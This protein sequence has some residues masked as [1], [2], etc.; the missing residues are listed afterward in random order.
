MTGI[1]AVTATSLL[2]MTDAVANW[3]INA[4]SEGLRAGSAE[5]QGKRLQ[6][7]LETAGRSG[8]PVFLEPG[9]YR[10]SDVTLP[11]QTVLHGVPG[12]TVLEYAGGGHFLF[13]ENNDQVSL[14]GLTLEGGLLPVDEY[15]DALVRINNAQRLDV[16]DCAFVDS[17]SCAIR[18]T[19]SSGSISKNRITTAVGSAAFLGHDNK[20]LLIDGNTLED[21]ANGGILVHRWNRGSDNTIVTNNRIKRIAAIN[22]GTGQ[23]GNGINTYQADGVIVARNHV[24]DCAFSTIRANACSNIQIS[25]NTCLR[26][27]ETSVYSEFA[28]E[29]AKITG[30]IID[31]GVTGI[32]IA[33]FNEGGRLSTCANNIIRNIHDRVPYQDE[34]HIQGIGISVEADTALTGNVIDQTAQFG[35]LLGWGPYL[36][37]VTASSNVVRATR[38]GM[39][40][41]VVEGI[42]AVN[43]TNNIF[44]KVSQGGI[45]GYRWHDAVTRDLALDT[46]HA[47]ATLNIAGN[48]LDF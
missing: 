48:K 16:Q 3:G 7:I 36:R 30:N 17:G 9:R 33:N 28:F 43:I 1:G 10:L 4:N 45:V 34:A 47:Y 24:S 18:V 32:S 39:Y 26:A 6:T 40:V 35:I 13:A 37:N 5:N 11:K 12:S 46:D 23:W 42:G 44:S 29:G 15:A 25:D 2:P 20:G 19:G 21:C 22:G 31:G 14:S 38:T 41:S 27:G 8:K